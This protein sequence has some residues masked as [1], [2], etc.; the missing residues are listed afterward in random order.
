MTR[1]RATDKNLRGMSRLQRGSPCST[2]MIMCMYAGYRQASAFLDRGT[3][4]YPDVRWGK[5]NDSD[6]LYAASLDGS[7]DVYKL[8]ST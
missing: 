7:I 6:V 3:P 4:N 2:L 8:G 5:G 1:I